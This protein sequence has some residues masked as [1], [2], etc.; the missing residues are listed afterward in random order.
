M[1]RNGN[2]AEVLTVDGR[3]I[4]VTRWNDRSAT[5]CL[6]PLEDVTLHPGPELDA[7]VARLGTVGF[8]DVLTAALPEPRTARLLDDGFE[9]RQRLCLLARDLADV[10]RLPRTAR[11]VPRRARPSDLD[12]VLAVDAAGFDEF[13]RFDAAALGEAIGATA[14]SRYRVVRTDGGR[15][16]GGYAVFGVADGCGFLQRLAVDPTRRR[17]GVA[18]A[19]LDDGFRWLRRRGAHTVLVNTQESNSQALAFYRA[20]GF[21]P[22]SHHLVVLGRRTAGAGNRT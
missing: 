1:S 18:T 22:E 14:R 6:V 15:D 8:D 11:P 9:V 4:R 12:A 13:W 10:R 2:G 5:A 21:V 3:R 17:S 19:L 16:V 7:L 20:V